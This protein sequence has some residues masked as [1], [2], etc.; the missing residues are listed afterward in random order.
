M[1]NRG[2]SFEYEK[3]KNY[4][5]FGTVNLT[6]LHVGVF[7]FAFFAASYKKIDSTAI[8]FVIFKKIQI[9]NLIWHIFYVRNRSPD[10]QT[11]VFAILSYFY[12]VCCFCKY[13]YF[14]PINLV[15]TGVKFN[16]LLLKI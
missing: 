1:F 13:L 2:R 16:G 15:R 8:R 4:S 12:K 11:R 9:R 6:R 5:I 10:I 7:F 3:K 14:F